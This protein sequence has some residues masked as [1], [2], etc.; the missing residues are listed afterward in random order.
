MT[1]TTP[2]WYYSSLDG[3][4]LRRDREQRPELCRGS[5][6]FIVRS[7]DYCTRPLQRA[8]FI[9]GI[10][11]S[12]S[13]VE[14]GYTIAAINAVRSSINHLATYDSNNVQNYVGIFTFSAAGVH[15]YQCKPGA[16]NPVRLFQSEVEGN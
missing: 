5:V 11:V 14:T 10:D 16:K 12:T 7:E 15:H 1:N 6:D 9:F 13:A 2:P 4:G 3:A 8:N